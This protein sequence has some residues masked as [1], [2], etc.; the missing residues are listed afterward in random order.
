[1]VGSLGAAKA[2]NGEGTAAR[3]GSF[4]RRLCVGAVLALLAG[5]SAAGSG[6]L[7]SPT[8]ATAR[9]L[10]TE[11]LTGL[12]AQQVVALLGEPDFRR[13]EP[14]AELWQYRSADCVLDLFL[15]G[16]AAGAHVV[17]SETRDRSLVPGGAGR[18]AVASEALAGR[19]RQSR[20]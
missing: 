6:A 18:C 16:D 2:A 12:S 19:M 9:Q 10:A 4:R 7:H 17:H 13:S 3:R 1:M 14:P 20:L 15:Y 5:C 11:P 8:T